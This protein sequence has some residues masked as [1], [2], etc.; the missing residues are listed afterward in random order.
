MKQ[1]KFRHPVNNGLYTTVL[2]VENRFAG[3]TKEA[4]SQKDV[5]LARALYTLTPYDKVVEGKTYKSLKRLFLETND[6]TGYTLATMYLDGWEHLQRLQAG[7]LKDLWPVWE[8]E[9]EVK[10]K[11]AG[12][13]TVF[14]KA[15]EGN[16][17]CAKFLTNKGWVKRKA[18]APTKDEKARQ[19]KIDQ[20]IEKEMAEDAVR[21]ELVPK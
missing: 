5:N 10:L 9:M 4:G 17:D 16:V 18:G 2:F 20:S 1:N 6:P 15:S 14:E 3:S 12:L 8:D 13:R 21:L 19:L 7:V 11:S